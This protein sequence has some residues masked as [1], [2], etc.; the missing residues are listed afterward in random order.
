MSAKRK[1]W[2]TR[3]SGFSNPM[4]RHESKAAVYRYVQN[5]V[6]NWLCGALRSK[7]LAVYVDN[8]EGLGWQLYEWVDLDE[9]AVSESRAALSEETR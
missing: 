6:A 8:R 4:K 2:A 9:L 3:Y 5:E 7:R 1:L